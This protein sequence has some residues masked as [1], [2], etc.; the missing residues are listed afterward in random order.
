MPLRAHASFLS[1]LSN[2][3]TGERQAQA[4]EIETPLID[5]SIH[6][7]Q[8]IPLLES[9][10]NPNIENTKNKDNKKNTKDN[11]PVTIVQNDAILPTDVFTGR[12]LED[13]SSDE[14]TV[15]K[16]K[17]GNTL[18][19]IAQQFD[20]SINTIR[21]ANHISGQKIR[22][23]QKLDILPVTG[24]KH[25]VKR[26]DTLSGIASKYEA[27]LNDIVVF[28][29]ISKN[30]KLRIGQ[31]IYVPNGIIRSYKKYSRRRSSSRHSNIKAPVGYYIRPTVGRISSPYGP[32]R[33]GFHYGV[34]IAN[35]RGTPIVAAASGIVVRVINYCVEGHPSCGGRY[36][37]FIIIQHP[38]DTKTRYAHLQK[39]LVFVGQRVKQGQLIAKMGDTGHSTGPHLHFEVINSN[40][41][42]MRP[43]VY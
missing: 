41:S 28:N 19:G 39:A 38:N 20:I 22:I 40:G 16:V 24:I 33:G 42:T 25:I 32:R 37:N 26:G 3:F 5:G 13:I 29:G 31:V 2:V 14:V 27:K 12:G 15:Y 1:M 7:S 8:T 23:G 10:I 34:D 9:S 11:Q 4:S 30:G 43:P 21:W 6:N 36:G 18:S 35:R 17:K